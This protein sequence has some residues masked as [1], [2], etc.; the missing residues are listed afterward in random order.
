MTEP[1]IDGADAK[2][3]GDILFVSAE[4]T[5]VID[6]ALVCPYNKT[7]LQN[8]G[9]LLANSKNDSEAYHA[10][11]LSSHERAKCR[12]YSR[13]FDGKSYRFV[14]FIL[15]TDGM[16]GQ[17]AKKFILELANRATP[18]SPLCA[19]EDDSDA[20]MSPVLPSISLITSL[21]HSIF[22]AVAAQVAHHK[23]VVSRE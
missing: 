9:G 3:R 18:L 8:F 13:F 19:K 2:L 4:G 16:L 1:L 15:T 23:R 7:Y 12:K 20:T 10:A 21:I 17:E 14:P 6:I 5:V 11:V 22:N